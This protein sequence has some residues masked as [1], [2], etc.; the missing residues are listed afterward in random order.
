M[1]EN[2]L[3]IR[4]MKIK[5]EDPSQKAKLEEKKKLLNQNDQHAPKRTSRKSRGKKITEEIR[6]EGH[7]CQMEKAQ[8]IQALQ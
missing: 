1:T 7:K 3:K 4:E 6:T 8:Q 5:V 2:S